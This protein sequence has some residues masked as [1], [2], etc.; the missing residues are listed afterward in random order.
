MSRVVLLL[1]LG[2][3]TVSKKRGRLGDRSRVAAAGGRT[4]A[5][6]TSER[7]TSSQS[8]AASGAWRPARRSPSHDR[9]VQ[10]AFS[11]SGTTWLPRADLQDVRPCE[12]RGLA[13]LCQ[14]TG[15]LVLRLLLDR[16]QVERIVTAAPRSPPCWSNVSCSAA[17]TRSA[18]NDPSSSS[19]NTS[20]SL[21]DAA[22]ADLVPVVEAGV[23][24]L[25]PRVGRPPRS[26]SRGRRRTAASPSRSARSTGT[27]AVVPLLQ[28]REQ[29]LADGLLVGRLRVACRAH[30]FPSSSRVLGGRG[31]R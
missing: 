4:A 1:V 17:F 30:G 11:S 16:L 18:R 13:E 25:V 20:S 24:P 15:R 9:R 14:L 26:D 27:D 12:G 6:P 8:I 19:A 3:L 5:R 7:T 29:F 2:M 23:Q 21:G 28:Q 22:D 31:H 10:S